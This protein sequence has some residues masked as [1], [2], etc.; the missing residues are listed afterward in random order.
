MDETKTAKT[1]EFVLGALMLGGGS[2]LL[3][4]GAEPSLGR[5][6]KDH[7][8]PALAATLGM[9]FLVHRAVTK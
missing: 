7:P 5:A 3:T 4:Q 9:G 2:Y 1:I 8:L 6:V